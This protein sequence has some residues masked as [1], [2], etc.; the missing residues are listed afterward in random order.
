[1]EK[2]KKFLLLNQSERRLLLSAALLI[3]V[4]RPSLRVFAFTRVRVLLSRLKGRPGSVP[5]KSR[6]SPG[7][8]EWAVRAARR[9]VPGRVSCLVEALTAEVLLAR[10]GSPARFFLG[11]ATGEAGGP[12]GFE[13]HAWVESNGRVIV[14]KEGFERFTPLTG[15]KPEG[16]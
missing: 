9:R 16:A 7:R 14:G 15:L 6:L 11:V 5:D 1:M 8:V 12:G 10:S 3:C 2:L 4:I 13:A